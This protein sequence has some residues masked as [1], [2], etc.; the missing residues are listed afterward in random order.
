[1][2]AGWDGFEVAFSHEVLYLLTDLAAHARA[3]FAALA[4]GGVYYAVM[5]VHTGSP[6]MAAWH[7]TSADG[8]QLPKLYDIDDVVATFRGAGFVAAASRL[9]MRFVPVV[10][11]GHDDRS[12]LLDWLEYYY[13]QKLMLRFSR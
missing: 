6:L 5:G 8:L 11:H 9:A 2:P 10:G 4:P 7:A 13:D 12:R 3:I 1:M